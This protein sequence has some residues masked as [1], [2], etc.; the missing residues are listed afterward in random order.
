MDEKVYVRLNGQRQFFHLWGQ[1]RENPVILYLHGGPGVP[2]SF[3]LRRLGEQLAE[4]FTFVCWDQRGCG[5]SY[6]PGRRQA[7]TPEQA[8]ADVDAAAEYLR[9][10]FGQEKIILVGHSY[11]SLLGLR[12]VQCH[13]EKAAFYIGIGQ[14]VRLLEGAFSLEEL[15][16]LPAFRRVGPDLGKWQVW[17]RL[18]ALPDFGWR[19]LRWL[20]WLQSG[21]RYF[22][23]YGALL[24]WAVPAN[25]LAEEAAL[26]VPV[27]FITGER[28][29]QCRP[30]L[31][32]AYAAK[33]HAPRKELVLLP[34][35]GHSPHLTAP[36]TVAE[37]IRRMLSGLKET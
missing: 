36:E 23:R 1:S 20:V 22:A 18:L 16:R 11:G 19:D 21:E 30:E 37:H 34:G 4:E 17:K 12:Y 28:D 35:L 2:D 14:H 27:G 7:L 29:R 32:E 5:R 10:R 31:L 25:L 26:P 6:A 9:K 13:P 3:R 24:A 15:R 8:L 33:L